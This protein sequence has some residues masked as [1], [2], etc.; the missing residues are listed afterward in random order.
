MWFFANLGDVLHNY[1]AIAALT[2][3]L[4]Q[5]CLLQ[6]LGETETLKSGQDLDTP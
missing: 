4:F 5:E 1:F 2:S 3:V 6:S